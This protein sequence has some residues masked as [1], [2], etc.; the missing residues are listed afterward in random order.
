VTYEPAITRGWLTVGM[1]QAR[2]NWARSDAAA[3]RPASAADP[4][5]AE[6][7]VLPSMSTQVWQ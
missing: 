3:R 2:P 5:R 6:R 1:S 7:A 4:A